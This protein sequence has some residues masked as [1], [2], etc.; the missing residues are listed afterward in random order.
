MKNKPWTKEEEAKFEELY[1]SNMSWSDMA[2]ELGRSVAAL[3][4]RRYDSLQYFEKYAA[5]RTDSFKPNIWTE[6]DDQ[7]LLK[8]KK[9]GLTHKTIGERIGRTTDAVLNRWQVLK[10]L[11]AEAGKS[12]KTKRK[13]LRCKQSFASSGPG[14]RLCTSCNGTNRDA[15]T[16][17]Y[18]VHLRA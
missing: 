15:Y 11:S 4:S 14:N 2:T 7:Q 5:N 1:K 9:Q 18:A 17:P 10:S 8:M 3:K 6:E 13:C 12:G 16:P